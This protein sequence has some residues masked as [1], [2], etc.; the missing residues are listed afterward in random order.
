MAASSSR[1]VGQIPT[2]RLNAYVERQLERFA[3]EDRA[4]AAEVEVEDDDRFA[5]FPADL[6]EYVDMHPIYTSAHAWRDLNCIYRI[7]S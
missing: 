2:D 7:Y 6:K 3:A 4:G 5:G 1:S